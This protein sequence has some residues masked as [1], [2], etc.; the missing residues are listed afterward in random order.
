[1]DFD[2]EE[3]LVGDDMDLQAEFMAKNRNA[4]DRLKSIRLSTRR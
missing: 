3:F 2:C 4:L 1:M